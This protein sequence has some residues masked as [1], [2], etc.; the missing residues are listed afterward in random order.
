[1]PAHAAG[2]L[3]EW[4]RGDG[5][6][7]ARI[8]QCGDQLCMT[9]TRIRNSTEGEKV[10]DKVIITVEQRTDNKISGVVYDP[11]R[12]RSFKVKMTIEGGQM[13]M[14]GCVAGGMFCKSMQWT[15]L[16]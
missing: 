16:R 1:M 10:G 3:G 14:S 5:V 8:A 15:R 7:H 6:A 9:N 2:F 4:A 11:Q 13:T 12:D